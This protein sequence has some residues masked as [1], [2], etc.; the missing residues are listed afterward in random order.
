MANM[1]E[2]KDGSGLALC[3][4]GDP[5]DCRAGRPGVPHFESHQ[6]A[7]KYYAQES[8]DVP[9]GVH[10]TRSVEKAPRNRDDIEADLKAARDVAHD[11]KM[12]ADDVM[13]DWED[14]GAP[15]DTYR[16][17]LY[18]ESDR[19]N[20]KVKA[21]EEELKA[22]ENHRSETSTKESLTEEI[23]DLQRELSG[24]EDDYEN[25]I[26]TA[27]QLKKRTY[28]I[29]DKLNRIRRERTDL[30]IAENRKE[31]ASLVPRDKEGTFG[32]F[33]SVGDY[34]AAT[35]KKH[36]NGGDGSGSTFTTRGIS[37]LN[38]LVDETRSQR[39]SLDG[40]DREQ[41]IKDGANPAAFLPADQV[42]YLR[43]K[44]AGENSKIGI[45][46]VDG[47]DNEP[48]FIAEE[49]KSGNISFS[50]E[51][52]E[53]KKEEYGTLIIGKDDDGKDMVWT[54]HPGAPAKSSGRGTFNEFKPGQK[55][56]R[57][58]I[59]ETA[60][61]DDVQVNIRK[62]APPSASQESLARMKADAAER[63]QRSLPNIPQ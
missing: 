31:T 56:S 55:V 39:K 38:D 57:K 24:W 20:A 40:D 32:K 46:E 60:G 5:K 63:N 17:G 22:S 34:Y 2:K 49:S 42:R 10:G 33:N 23:K 28:P 14:Q 12:I 48:M 27:E 61:T 1:H 62:P 47:D 41:L 18:D 44:T 51:R 8:K 15:S 13:D 29:V 58:Q 54:A 11:E 4:A 37:S 36:F 59:R 6:D 30:I 7:E 9:G 43:V 45:N 21:L 53:F 25:G 16:A 35:D 52:G 19:A 50:V 26:H 3:Q